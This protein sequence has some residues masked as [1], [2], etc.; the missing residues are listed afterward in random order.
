[1]VCQALADCLLQH[2]I[3]LDL[4]RPCLHK[5]QCH[6]CAVLRI[7]MCH[8]VDHCAVLLIGFH[9]AM[10]V[11]LHITGVH[12]VL[13]CSIG[14]ASC[15]VPMPTCKILSGLAL[16]VSAAALGHRH[17]QGG[18]GKAFLVGAAAGGPRAEAR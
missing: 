8:A 17:V 15:C 14:L 1:M 18:P 6:T 5:V 7:G 12:T 4:W 2:Y 11:M 3:P 16:K 13:C 9:R 10:C